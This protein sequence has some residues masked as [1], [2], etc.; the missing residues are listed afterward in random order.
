[1]SARLFLA[2][3][4]LGMGS[5]VPLALAANTPAVPVPADALPEE[6]SDDAKQ[7]VLQFLPWNT[8]KAFLASSRGASDKAFL[9]SW[10]ASMLTRLATGNK[11]QKIKI[12][13]QIRESFENNAG[14]FSGF[15]EMVSALSGLLAGEDE[16]MRRHV[17]AALTHV[18]AEWS[19]KAI[20]VL[21]SRLAD[22]EDSFWVR[23]EIL[24][25]REKDL[26]KQSLKLNAHFEC[27]KNGDANVIDNLF[28]VF[29][30]RL[31]DGFRWTRREAV[32]VLVHVDEK[33]GVHVIAA[34]R[35]LYGIAPGKCGKFCLRQENA[36]ALAELVPKMN[37]REVVAQL[38]R[39]RFHHYN[40]TAD[41]YSYT[42]LT[43]EQYSVVRQRITDALAEVVEKG[44]AVVTAALSGRLADAEVADG[45]SSSL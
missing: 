39:M 17:E 21:T 8:F 37:A 22:E 45:S 23:P 25:A 3:L 43:D 33:G 30:G 7:S 41:F 2:A 14:L 38:S 19:G 18:V 1:M 5:W 4:L 31:A 27:L 24:K 13:T 10:R 26:C 11:C 32:K 29:S 35:I 34:P 15:P 40:R 36:E 6:W 16:D 9:A 20:A 42:P 28:V 44:N 12:L